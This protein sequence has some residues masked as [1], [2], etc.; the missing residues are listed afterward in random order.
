MKAGIYLGK[1]N[2]EGIQDLQKMIQSVQVPS[3]AFQSTY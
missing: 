3:A 2:V 1:G